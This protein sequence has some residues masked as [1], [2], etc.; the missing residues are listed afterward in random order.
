M[1]IKEITRIEEKLL[2]EAI[3]QCYGYDFRNYAHSSLRRR[4]AH[5]M[6]LAKLKHV[7]ELIPKVLHDKDFFN[8]LLED[9]SITVTE[10]FRDPEIYLAIRE[11]VVPILKT[12]PF[13]KIWDAGCATGEEIYSL[14]II[15]QEEDFYHR[16]HFYATDMNNRAIEVAREGIYPVGNLNEFSGN[17]FKAGGKA[18]LS[19]YFSCKYQ[20]AMISK[21]LKKNIVFSHHNL[22]SDSSFGEMNL[23]ICSNVLIYF[24]K[25]LQNRVLSLF[26]ESLCHGGFLCLGSKESLEF[27]DVCE[28]FEAITKKARIYKKIK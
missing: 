15:F 19:D 20:S 16:S 22:V 2:L 11:K 14:A 24:D 17:Y 26:Y 28:N 23:I 8:S 4:I 12:F 1:D 25:I 27:T 10:M 7:S 13:A 5:R 9:L 21:S 18:S 3:F 6:D